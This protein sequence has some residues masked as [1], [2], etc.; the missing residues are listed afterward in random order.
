M[1]YWSD[2]VRGKLG[3]IKGF[4][5]IMDDYSFNIKALESIAKEAA[6]R[7][8]NQLL[9]LIDSIFFASGISIGNAPGAV[10][11]SLPVILRNVVQSPTGLTT[12]GQGIQKGATTAIGATVRGLIGRMVGEK[13]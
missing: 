12:I 9:G 7:N 3:E 13:K 8:N 2:A 4:A 6:R 5:N 10:A 11:G 1:K